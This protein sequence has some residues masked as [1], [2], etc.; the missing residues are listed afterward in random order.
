M[1]LRLVLHVV[2][3][4]ATSSC[5]TPALD[6]DRLS[7]PTIQLAPCSVPNSPA[8]PRC[9][10]HH[11]FEDR[12]ARAGR[13]IPLKILVLPALGATPAPDPIFIFAGGPGGGAASEVTAGVVDYFARMRR[14]RDIVFVDQRGTGASHRLV[15]RLVDRDASAQRDFGDLLPPDKVRAC[16]QALEPI[17]DLR[18]YTTPIAMDDLDEVR[19]GLGYASINLYGVSYGALAALQYLRQYPT[20]VRSLALLGV[21]TPAQKLPLAFAAGAQAALDHVVADCAA[22]DA[23]QRAFPDLRR[24]LAAVFGRFDAGPVTFEHPVAGGRAAERVSM[25]RAVFAER[26]RLMLY[27]LRSASRIP[28]VIH[29]AAQDDWASFARATGPTL[30][31]ISSSFAMGMYLTVTCSESIPLISEDD[32]VRESRGTF[33][34]ETRTRVH[35]RACEEWPRGA[36]PREFYAPVTSDVPVLMVSGELDPA[37]PASWATLAARSLRNGRQLLVR[38]MAH[39]YFG[40]CLRGVVAE[41][42]DQASARELDTGCLASL[43]RPP[44]ATEHTPAR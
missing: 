44:F 23:C 4:A 17:A 16:R 8:E 39:W 31:G 9:A 15:C 41:F 42:F 12:A 22:D 33:V 25:P 3:F 2:L 40:D 13:M 20:R 30:T 5:A 36:I 10:T 19:R 32:I 43:R 28:L 7:V 34:G 38:N 26:L 35:V 29:R 1:K 37:T 18:L 11:V 24:D 6:S 21:G 14:T 27:D